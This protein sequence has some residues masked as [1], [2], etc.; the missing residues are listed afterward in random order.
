M[1]ETGSGNAVILLGR[2]REREVLDCALDSARD[3]LSGVLVLR[4]EPGAGKTALLEYAV[5]RSGDLRLARVAGIESEMDLGF[6]AVHQLLLP[7]LERLDRLPV[8][9]RDALRTILGLEAGGHAN[10]FLVGLAILTLLTDAA[11][12]QPL[13]LIVDDAHW[14]DRESAEVLAFV[15]RRLYADAV[16]CLFAV[17]EPAGRSLPLDGLASLHV[18]GLPPASARE[19]LVS[20]AGRPLAE[21]VIGRVVAETGG[22]PLA[23]VE[24]AGELADGELS[25]GSLPPEPLPVGTRLKERFLQRVS[26]LPA[27]TRALLLLAAAG[28]SGD[29]ALL[30]RAAK[31]LGIDAGAAAAAEASR[32]VAFEPNVVFRHSLVRSAVY[33]GASTAE[34]RVAHGALAAASDPVM[35]PDRRAWHR[36]AAAIGPDEEVAD[37]LALCADRARE[38]GGYAA[39]AALLVRAAELTPRQ[40][41]RA[42]RLLAAAGAELSAGV[43]VRARELLDRAAPYLAEPL[44]RAQVH[45]LRGRIR[46]A[47]GRGGAAPAVLLEAARA[48]EPLDPGRA[49][50]T[51]LEAL[52]AALY[53][54]RTVTGPGAGQVARAV[55]AAPPVPQSQATITDLLLCGYSAVLIGER[56]A[57]VPLLRR[58]IAALLEGEFPLAESV[59]WL[60]LG[61]RAAGELMDD[62]ALHAL[63][64]HAVQ[65]T[66]DAGALTALPLALT[67]LGMSEFLSG[68]FTAAQACRAEGLEI[69]AATRNPGILGTTAREDVLVLAWRGREAETRWS[70]AALIRDGTELGRG[71]AISMA[72]HALAMLELGLGQYEAALVHWLDIYQEDPFFHGTLALPGLIEA[73]A[74]SGDGPTARAALDRF[75]ERALASGTEWALGLLARSSALLAGD[76]GAE[77]LYREA[78]DRLQRTRAAPDLARAHLLYGEWLRRRRRRRDARAELRTAHQMLESMGAGAFATRAANELRATGEHARQRNAETSDDLTPQEAQIARLVADGA[79]NREIAEKLFISASTVE[80]HLR[81]VFRKLDLT[82]RTQLARVLQ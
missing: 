79:S 47:L 26:G 30:W 1:V 60:L 52:E 64:S 57:G 27:D 59:R 58:A 41:C 34:R 78:I 17:D 23:L 77:A 32:L 35:D 42:Q 68:Q 22:N 20:L 18:G 56:T 66:R 69:S 70:A 46:F 11:E 4:G 7:F 45:W 31:G 75:S 38:R 43:P 74:R 12:E 80:Y 8:P 50:E 37:E 24:I 5:A 54:G 53:A 65:L 33:H 28:P 48:F 6:A 62:E 40:S 49:R 63:A 25:R 21:D 2:G 51:L 15:A 39:A 16:T 76:S 13:L 44:A 71:V 10:R 67:L 81:K 36:A 9:Q 72:L 3:G 19:L 14:L 55:A 73:A 61:G 29:P 82:S